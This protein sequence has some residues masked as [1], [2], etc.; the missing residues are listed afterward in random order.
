MKSSNRQIVVN[1]R[2]AGAG[3]PPYLHLAQR[4]FEKAPPVTS[5]ESATC[6]VP[7]DLLRLAL[8][9]ESALMDDIEEIEVHYSTKADPE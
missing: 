1:V 9:N 6:I 7:V 2:K 4:H 5:G 3:P 8:P